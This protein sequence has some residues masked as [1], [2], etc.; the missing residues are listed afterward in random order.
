MAI[1]DQFGNPIQTRAL[2]EPQTAR[3]ASLHQEFASHPVRGLTPAK[4][5]GI[6]ESAETGDLLAQNDLFEDMEEKD[7]HILAEMGKRKR[8]LLGLEWSIQPPRNATPEEEK[9]AAYADEV[10]RDLPDLEDVMFDLLDAIGKGY[11]CCEIEWRLDG[12]EWLPDKIEHR[13]PRWFNVDRATRAE[14]RLRDMSMDGQALQ[15]FGWLTHIHK[16]KS[17]YI[18]RSGLGRCLVWPFL[19]K[20][21]SVRDL[22]EFLEIYGLPLR[23]GTYPSGASDD[24]KRTLLQAVVNIGHA[25][26]GIVPEGMMIDFK[27]AAK[28]TEGPFNSMIDWCE[29]T[30]SKAILG[31]TLSAEAK[32]TGM[33]S[34]VATLQGDVRWDLTISDARQLN[35]TLTRDLVYPILAL[36]KGVTS[37]RRSPRFA[38][39]TS[40]S[41]ELNTFSLGIARMVSV[42]TRIPEKWVHQKLKI[43]EPEGDEPILMPTQA[44]AMADPAQAGAPPTAGLRA[45]LSLPGGGCPHCAQAALTAQAPSQVADPLTARLSQDAAPALKDWLDHIRG[46]VDQAPDLAFLRDQLL[47]AYGDLPSADLAKIMQLGFAAA[48]LAGRFD[49]AEET[50]TL[51]APEKP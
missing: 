34:G 41:E 40:T 31:Q 48:A 7:G 12:R 51:R 35:G 10:I 16:A 36:N 22:A 26:A 13:P 9:L 20:N 17:G 46:L 8:A 6:L 15:P 45:H 49:V 21:Y 42:G 1:V 25:A 30:E 37:L 43:P 50:G 11:S 5:A 19:F 4:L 38:F 23:L 3:V 32:A 39:D 47:A 24:E 18:T 2:K 14:L 33:G 27:E 44:S 29:R 28:G